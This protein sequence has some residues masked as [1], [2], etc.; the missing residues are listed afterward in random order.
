MVTHSEE[1]IIHK[2][3]GGIET[4]RRILETAADLFARK[5][6]DSVSLREIAQAA[7]IRESS[8]YNHFDGKTGIL[9]TL[10]EDFIRLTPQARPTDAELDQMLA[11]MQPEEVFKNILFHFASAVSSVLTN[12]AM[13]INQEKFK[14]PQ[15]ADM[16]YKYVV[17]EPADFYERLINKMA[18]RAMIKPVDARAIA[19]QYNYVSITLTKEYFMALNGLA[20]KEA[21]VKTT[22]KAVN[23]FCSLIKK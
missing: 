1:K 10:F 15:A 20:D 7:G 4:R 23:F 2:R 17:A 16:Y 6:V 19:E 12:T 21:V 5:G 9:E 14:N 11:I 3:K 8:L 13:I 22:L 18:A